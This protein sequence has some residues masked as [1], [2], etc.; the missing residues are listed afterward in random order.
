MY[1]GSNGLELSNICNIGSSVDKPQCYMDGM[2]D[3]P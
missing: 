3:N 1:M 2:V